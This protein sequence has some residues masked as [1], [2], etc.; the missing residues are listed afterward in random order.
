MNN[1]VYKV[2]VQK[3]H[4]RTFV[5]FHRDNRSRTYSKPSSRALDMLDWVTYRPEKYAVSCIFS[6]NDIAV[7]IKPNG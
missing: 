5:I 7:F 2:Q 4:T 1:K 6:K 3:D